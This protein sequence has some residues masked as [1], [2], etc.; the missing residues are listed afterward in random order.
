MKRRVQSAFG[1]LCAAVLGAV[2]GKLLRESYLKPDT[3]ENENPPSAAANLSIP[4]LVPGL[5]AA[6]K[7]RE[8]PWVWFH[9]PTW[10]VAFTINF[11]YAMA[12]GDLDEVRKSVTGIVKRQTGIDIEGVRSAM[13]SLNAESDLW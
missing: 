12:G 2:L 10:A 9:V 5:I 11:L 7:N 4:D 3:G 6:G 13:E 8:A 1:V